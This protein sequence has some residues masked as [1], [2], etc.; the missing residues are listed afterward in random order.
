MSSKPNN[1][2]FQFSNVI[3]VSLAHFAH[4]VYTAFLA[5]ILPL[6]IEK[7]GISYFL[8]GLLKVIQTL[9]TLLNPLIGIFADKMKLRYLI[10][11][12]PAT[13]TVLMSLIGLSPGYGLLAILLFLVG[14][15]STFFHVP[16]PV[17]IRKIS[18][19]KIGKGM[20][21]FMVGGEIA[22]TLG[23]III[24]AAISYW[25]LE[26]TYRLIPF[27]LI[28]TAILYF[29]FRKINISENVKKED[30]AL[31]TLK[32]YIPF[33]IV[34]AGIMFFRASMKSALTYYLPAYLTE[35]GNSLW[36][37]GIALSVL[38][39]AGT[40]GTLLAGTISDKIG[41][42]KSLIIITSIT[43][44]LMWLF[45]MLD[46]QY[47]FAILIVLGFFLFASSPVILALV[48]EI[49]SDRPAFINSIYML[50]N[51]TISAVCVIL[52]GALTDR[53]GF[54][55]SYKI[56]AFLAFGSLPFA[57]MLKKTR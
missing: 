7:L 33:F 24:L 13:T 30:P 57:L 40:G 28:T 56:T 21:F 6:I 20:S 41:R 46:S 27:G 10:I 54:E 25:G 39:L 3:T 18:G 38:Q 16:A 29:K 45:V 22:R 35:S 48:N 5:P 32:K 26:G 19:D 23:P 15:S 36:L 9:P 47:S 52:V 42:K 50:I 31:R 44:I 49:K 14:I 43:P 55:I 17:M 8:V 34:I 51:F 37:A 1:S 12:T 4:D 11:I 2:K 53:F